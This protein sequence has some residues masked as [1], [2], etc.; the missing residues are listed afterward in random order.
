MQVRDRLIQAAERQFAARGTLETTLADIRDEV[1][2]SVGA[3]YHHFPDKAQLYS[4][5]W[6][7]ALADYQAAFWAAIRDSETAEEGVRSGV[8]AHLDWVSREPARAKI[9]VA[10][11]PAAARSSSN[12]EFLRDTMRWWRTHAAYGAVR[13]LEF[14]LVYALWLGPAQE[15]ARQ[16]LSGQLDSAPATVAETLGEAAW[17]SL[18]TAQQEGNSR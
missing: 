7:H 8:R 12:T 10:P 16:W 17:Q 13:P 11:R 3:L 15:Y 5:V 1:G 6:E 14:P 9:L 2:V 18:K 4:A